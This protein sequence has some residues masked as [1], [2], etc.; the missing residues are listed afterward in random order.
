MDLLKT[1][2]DPFTASTYPPHMGALFQAPDK[3]VKPAH[4]EQNGT[5]DEMT[6]STVPL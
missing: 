6:S 5:V 2:S 4:K 3:C 1:K